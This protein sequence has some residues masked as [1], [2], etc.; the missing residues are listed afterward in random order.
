MINVPISSA[1]DRVFEAWSGQA[2][3]YEIEMCCFS[4]KHAA[5][6]KK[7]KDWLAWNQINVS[8][9]SDRSTR[10]CCFETVS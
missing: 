8:E 10:V 5:L 7:G 9:W 6:R 1:E 3:D 4:A 2:K